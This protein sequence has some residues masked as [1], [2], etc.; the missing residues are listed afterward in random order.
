MFVYIT[1]VDLVPALPKFF[2]SWSYEKKKFSQSEFANVREKQ[3]ILNYK[4]INIT[5]SCT[6]CL[7]PIFTWK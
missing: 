1:E 2:F 3:L 4:G 5:W 6:S 7:A